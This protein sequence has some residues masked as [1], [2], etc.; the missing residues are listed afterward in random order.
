MMTGCCEKTDLVRGYRAKAYYGGV[1]LPVW[2]HGG[3]WRDVG[4]FAV[5]D[6][7]ALRPAITLSILQELL[8]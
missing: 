3:N 6:E 8:S 7:S 1:T 4:S 2:L 5:V